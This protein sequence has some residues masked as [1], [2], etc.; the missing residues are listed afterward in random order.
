MRFWLAL[1]LCCFVS[2]AQAKNPRHSGNVS[3]RGYTNKYGTYVAPHVRTRPDGNF[4]NNWST[5]GNINPYTGEWGTKITPAKSAYSP[6][7]G[8]SLNSALTVPRVGGME[9]ASETGFLPHTE[10]PFG[11]GAL[12]INPYC[13][14]PKVLNTIGDSK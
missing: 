13:Q 9:E 11:N 7:T 2:L 12:I 10:I 4:G 1:L 5:K 6:G 8:P 14:R 3:V